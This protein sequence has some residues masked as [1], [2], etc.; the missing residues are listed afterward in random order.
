[1]LACE[2][3]C[4]GD[5]CGQGIL[6]I[7]WAVK[8]GKAERGMSWFSEGRPLTISNSTAW[9]HPNQMPRS[10]LYGQSALQ[11]P[12]ELTNGQQDAFPEPGKSSPGS[13]LPNSHTIRPYCT[14]RA[15][16]LLCQST[17]VSSDGFNIDKAMQERDAN[18]MELRGLAPRSPGAFRQ[19]KHMDVTV[20]RSV[21]AIPT[22]YH[23]QTRKPRVQSVR[24]SFKDQQPV[25]AL[26]NFL[27]ILL[28]PSS[29]EISNRT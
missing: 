14:P 15:E 12:P 29:H 28:P 26:P 4:L 18:M 6:G 22:C 20:P 7:Y 10:H 17:N 21:H 2:V 24:S 16:K 27:S 1:M 13:V 25:N 19:R 9:N 5:N 11:V 8:K 23:F 3:Q